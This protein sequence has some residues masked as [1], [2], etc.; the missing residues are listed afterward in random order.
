MCLQKKQNKILKGICGSEGKTGH[1]HIANVLQEG[2]RIGERLP[3][4]ALHDLK[5][6]GLPS[7]HHGSFTVPM[8]F[9]GENGASEKNV[10][11]PKGGTKLS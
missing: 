8:H 9:I 5:N 11:V 1:H 6:C 7:T 4:A 10:V 2:Q 3:L